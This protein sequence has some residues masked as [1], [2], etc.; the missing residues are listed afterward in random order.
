M[1]NKFVNIL[2]FRLVLFSLEGTFVVEGRMR[3]F[4]NSSR[5]SQTCQ[6]YWTEDTCGSIYGP[7]L[8]ETTAQIISDPAYTV[9]DFTL[10]NSANVGVPL[11]FFS[12]CSVFLICT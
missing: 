8:V 12:S 3:V 6:Q 11:A 2:K 7:F 5:M 10:T 4:V 1:H 9:R